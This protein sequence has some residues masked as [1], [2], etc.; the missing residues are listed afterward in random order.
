MARRN[1]GGFEILTKLPW[2]VGVVAGVLAFL[3]VRYGIPWY[4]AQSGGPIGKAFA[5][6]G[7]GSSLSLLAWVLLGVCWL[8]AGL[9]FLGRKQRALLYESQAARPQLEALGWRQ[10]EQLVGEWFRRN[11]YSVAETGGGGSDGGVDLVVRKDG[12]KEL[13]QCKQWRRRKVDVAT[14]REM[15]GLLQ[16]H[17]AAAVWI[18]SLGPFTSDAARFAN[19]KPIQ[20]VMGAQLVSAMRPTAGP[21]EGP[22]GEASSGTEAPPCPR[23]GSPMARRQNR[24]TGEAFM[25]CTSF[26]RCRETQALSG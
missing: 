25:G 2:P 15:W 11:G 9:S 10:F 16:H 18:V 14:V 19:G 7:P 12:R 22:A 13:V 24:K 26:P 5:T 4:L 8:A 20:L 21:T 23:C 17:R 6:G 3:A 1:E